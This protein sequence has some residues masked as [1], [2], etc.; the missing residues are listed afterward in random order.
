MDVWTAGDE[1]AFSE[2]RA[3]IEPLLFK[4][5]LDETHDAKVSRHLVDETLVRIEFGAY[6]HETDI[7]SWALE[8]ATRL[9]S[10]SGYG[11]GWDAGAR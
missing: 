8:V 3:C 6:R 10:V 2:M 11:H 4:Y 9:A 7:V 1:V 5:L